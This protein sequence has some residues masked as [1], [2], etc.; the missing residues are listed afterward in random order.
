MNK[1]ANASF[2]LVEAKVHGASIAAAIEAAAECLA[3][4]MQ[5]AH[6]GEWRTMI[7]HNARIVLVRMSAY[8]RPVTPMRRVIV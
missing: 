3:G 5:Q 8:E 6:G 2:A 7:D 1:G 4:L